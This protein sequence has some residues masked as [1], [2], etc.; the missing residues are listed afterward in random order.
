MPT[1]ILIQCTYSKREHTAKARYL[2]GTSNYFVKQRS[3]AKAK[4]SETGGDWYILSA[5]Y[6]L[7]EPDN[8]LTPYDEKG[9]TESQ[10][11]TIADKL[12][13]FTTV[14]IQAGRE[15]TVPLVPELESYGIDVI[16]HCSGM[17][18]GERMSELNEKIES[19]KN[20]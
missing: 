18:I 7:V 5:K 17:R 13:D 11:E 15:Y 19:L 12:Q 10:A 4:S 6:G 9:L 1:A 14:H 2:Y 3:W 16:T 8:V 20:A